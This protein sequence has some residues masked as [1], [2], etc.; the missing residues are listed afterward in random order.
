[1]AGVTRPFVQAGHRDGAGVDPPVLYRRVTVI[2][3]VT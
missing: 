1:M 3:N 2:G